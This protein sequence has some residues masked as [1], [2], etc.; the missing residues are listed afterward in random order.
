[1][2]NSGAPTLSMK[3]FPQRPSTLE[4][5]E[6]CSVLNGLRSEERQHL[7]GRSFMAYAEKGEYIWMAGSPSDFS[8]VIGTGFAKMTRGTARGQEVAVELLGPGQC[9]G[10]LVAI[11]GRPFPLSAIAVTDCWY[12]KILTAEFMI[13]YNAS[14]TL[15]D[16][17]VRSIGPRLRKAYDMVTRLSSGKVEERLAV[18]LFIL[19]G[20]YGHETESGLQLDV[21][22]TRQDLSEMAGTT[23]ETTIRVLSKWQKLGIVS[24]ERQVITILNQAKLE[25]VIQDG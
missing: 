7:A 17:V 1:M 3:T 10:L 15:K 20:S 21:P 16:Q 2:P 6:A 14:P 5:I 25:R 9:M 24:T 4:V 8:A 12:L 19:A 13:L 11:E 22:L 18:V 23:T